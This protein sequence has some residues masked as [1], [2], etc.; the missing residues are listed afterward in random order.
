MSSSATK[1]QKYMSKIKHDEEKRLQFLKM[2][3]ERKQEARKLQRELILKNPKLLLKERVKKKHEMARYRKNL[4]KKKLMQPPNI[5]QVDIGPYQTRASFGRAIN[6]VKKNLPICSKK[7]KTVILELAKQMINDDLVKLIRKK[8]KVGHRLDPEIELSIINFYK[9]NAISRQAPCKRDVKSIKDPVTGE[10][11]HV[12]IRH[13][14]MDISEAY[15]EYKKEYPTVNVSLAKFFSLRPEFILPVANLL[16]NVCICRYH[17]DMNFLIKAIDNIKMLNS[18]QLLQKLCC[19]IRNEDC[20]FNKC[21]NCI[22]NV[23]EIIPENLDMRQVVQFKRWESVK[24]VLMIV[25]KSVLLGKIIQD[26]NTKLPVF[27]EHC[28]VKNVQFNHFEE[29]KKVISSDEAVLQCDFAENF[30]I[31][32]QDEI[33]SAHWRHAQVTI[34]TSC[35]WYMG[36][37]E[38]YV[39]ISDDLLHSKQAT[40]T[41]LKAIIDDFKTHHQNVKKIHFFSDNCA[42]QFRSKY[43]VSNI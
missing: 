29:L 19:D 42:S 10:R 1:Q 5:N 9:E 17:A 39:V 27:K 13:L 7:K 24:G 41:F 37:V 33:Q 8:K 23:S 4:K 30:A 43:T 14:V 40:Y 32:A 6:K 25:E 26:I 35:I 22:K 20:M 38:S 16:H 21:I 3:R 31:K 15:S 18:S 36:E 28:Y 2:D 12:Q 34:F 11:S